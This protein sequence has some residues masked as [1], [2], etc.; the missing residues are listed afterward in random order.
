MDDF[1]CTL[2]APDDFRMNIN[3]Q[4]FFLFRFVCNVLRKPNEQTPFVRLAIE[5]DE[6]ARFHWLH[7][8]ILICQLKRF[9]DYLICLCFK[10]EE[11]SVDELI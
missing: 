8:N 2:M 11:K 1:N 4:L 10:L 3:E 5:R 6:L 7:F 9:S